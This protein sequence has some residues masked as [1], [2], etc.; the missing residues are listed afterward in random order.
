MYN[1]FNFF[2]NKFVTEVGADPVNAYCWIYS[3]F[4]VKKHLRGIPGHGIAAPGV[5]HASKNDEIYNHHYYQWVTN[6][7]KSLKNLL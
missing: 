6:E 7:K 4:T 1:H 2:I 5:A 3:T